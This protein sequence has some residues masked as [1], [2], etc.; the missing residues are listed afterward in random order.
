MPP[1][2][3]SAEE[4]KEWFLCCTTSFFAEVLFDPP[5]TRTDDEKEQRRRLA[6]K[7]LKDFLRP[8]LERGVGKESY[9]G[10]VDAVFE[11]LQNPV[12][13]KQVR[14]SMAEKCAWC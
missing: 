1:V 13:N 14:S 5:V 7:N 9:E 4:S 6:L 3:R 12:I 2:G 10:G 11:A 8:I